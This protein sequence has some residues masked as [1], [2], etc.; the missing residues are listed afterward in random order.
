M[1]LT[2][3]PGDVFYMPTPTRVRTFRVLGVGDVAIHCQELGDVPAITRTAAELEFA[4]VTLDRAK[5]FAYPIAYRQHE[6][7]EAQNALN[8]ATAAIAVLEK[9]RDEGTP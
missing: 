9:E 1:P 8:R 4:G 2:F 5:A 7:G 6:A 3:K